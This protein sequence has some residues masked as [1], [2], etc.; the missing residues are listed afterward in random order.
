[1]SLTTVLILLSGL[2][3]LFYGIVCCFSAK[4][5]TEFDRFGLPKFAT[6]IGILEILG[7]LGLLVGLKIH[8][9]LLL[10]SGGLALLMLLGVGVRIKVKDS[11]LLATPAFLLMLLNLYIFMVSI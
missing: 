6:L 2:V 9:I 1:M 4:M 11:I 5:K 8:F 10:S 7:G 3:F